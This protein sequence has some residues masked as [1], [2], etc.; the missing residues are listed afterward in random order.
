M[1]TIVRLV[2]AALLL[3]AAPASAVEVSGLF[4]VEVPVSGQGAAERQQAIRTGFDGVLTKVTGRSDVAAAPQSEG[5]RE[6]AANYVQQYRYRPGPEVEAGERSQLLWI[7]FDRQ[8]L[9]QALRRAGVSVWGRARPLTLVWAAVERDGRRTLVGA[10]D[11]GPVREAVLAAADARGIPV[12]FPLLDLAEQGRVSAADV[13]GGFTEPL[14]EASRRYGAQAVLAL[15]VYQDT[16]GYWRTRW[17]LNLGQETRRWDLAEERLEGVL[18]RG[19]DMAA[20][21]LASRFTGAGGSARS[22]ALLRVAGVENL[23][24]YQRSRNYLAGLNGVNAVE[25]H[26]AS[27]GAVIYRLEL[28]VGTQAL[29]RSIPLGNVLAPVAGEGVSADAPPERQVLQY[30]LRP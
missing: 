28:E 9:E 5:L 19:V 16:G 6:A 17:A 4:E 3:L 11:I 21:T 20:D 18:G 24:G 22:S 26:T 10:T 29:A 30:R 12:R 1:N 15:R 25:V 7:R 2:F 14:Q 23:A 27:P 13:W 8:A